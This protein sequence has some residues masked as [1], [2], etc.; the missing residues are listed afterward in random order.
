[1]THLDCERLIPSPD[2]TWDLDHNEY[3]EPSCYGMTFGRYSNRAQTPQKPEWSA[4]K[5]EAEHFMQG[6]GY[7]ASAGLEALGALLLSLWPKGTRRR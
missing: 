5:R 7:A 1:M 6:V 3:G 4:E 2:E